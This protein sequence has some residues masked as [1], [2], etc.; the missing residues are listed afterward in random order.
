[1]VI[2]SLDCLACHKETLA[3]KMGLAD[4][5]QLLVVAGELLLQ[6]QPSSRSCQNTPQLS[7]VSLACSRSSVLSDT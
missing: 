6:R 1:M 3:D 5:F 4:G 2:L 7:S